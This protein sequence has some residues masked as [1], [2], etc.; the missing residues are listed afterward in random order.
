MIGV[1]VYGGGGAVVIVGL[2]HIVISAE[3]RPVGVLRHAVLVVDGHDLAVLHPGAGV[4]DLV[5][6]RGG[7][8]GQRASV[9]IEI[10]AAGHA[11]VL[12]DPL[13]AVIHIVITGVVILSSVVQS[14]PFTGESGSGHHGCCCD[15]CD[16]SYDFLDHHCFL[17]SLFFVIVFL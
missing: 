10:V 3:V 12:I 17:S 9:L 14:D 6:V 8:V 11:V 7:G 13:P 15:C 16:S 5:A 4:V 2:I 1:S